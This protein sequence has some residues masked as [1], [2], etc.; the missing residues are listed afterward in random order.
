MKTKIYFLYDEEHFVRYVGKTVK[1]LQDRLWSHLDG[2]RKGI[3]THKGAWI[4]SMLKKGLIPTIE[5]QTEVN[6]DGNA[7][8]IAYIK[9]FRKHGV[10]LT[11]GTLGGDGIIAGSKMS[12]ETRKKMSEGRK[13]IRPTEE[14]RRKLSEA[15]M[16][17]Q[18]SEETKRRMSLASKGRRHSE[19]TKK[20]LSILGKGRPNVNK[21]KHFPAEVGLKM[22]KSRMGHFVSEET[23]RKISLAHKGKKFSEESR[24]KMSAANIGKKLSEET[25]R[26]I[27]EASK[28][29]WNKRKQS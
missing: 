23:K 16:G 3:K 2:A 20:L 11:N 12:L 14:T 8:E 19:K 13:G 21:G 15:R 29:M 27:G 18:Y 24:M 10:D 6:G 4:R 1:S 26:K 7:A 9:Y 28:I 25:K 5:L 22:S 17:I